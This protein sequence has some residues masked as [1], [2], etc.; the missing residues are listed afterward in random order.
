MKVDNC[1]PFVTPAKDV[2]TPLLMWLVGI[3]VKVLRT[4]PYQPTDNA[5][6]ERM[7]DLTYRWAE[8]FHCNSVEQLN[9]ALEE[10]GRINRQ[11]YP[12]DK[13][14]GKTRVQV[15]TEPIKP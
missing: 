13:F 5:I 3:G 10:V 7:Q 6:V 1:L 14:K 4:R 9:Q 15:Y 12:C 2:P 8:P 11:E